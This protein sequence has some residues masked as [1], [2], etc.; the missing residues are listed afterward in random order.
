MR[1]ARSPLGVLALGLALAGCRPRAEVD[2]SVGDAGAPEAPAASRT[3]RMSYPAG[4]GS[5]VDVVNDARGAIVSIHS[6]TPIKS[7]PAAMFPG[8]GD[9]AADVALGTG[10]LI[11]AHGV[12]VVT[13][14]HIVSAASELRV[15]TSDRKEIV[16]RVIGRDP[17]L[18]LALLQVDAPRLPTL[19]L[20]N[21]KDLDVGEW[22]V[23]LGD[24]FGDEV[25]ASAGI[26]SATGR[27][28]FGSAVAGPAS[29]YRTYLQTD[30]R[31]HRGNSGGPVLDTAGQVIGVAVATDD[32]PGEISFAIPIDQVK[33]VIESLREHG[34]VERAYLGATVNS[35]P[36][37][38]QP[39]L[40]QSGGAV[41]TDVSRDTPA[42][43]A[44]LRT[45]DV[46][47]EWDGRE[48]DERSLPPLVTSAVVGKRIPV[49]IFR[50]GATVEVGVT[51]EKLPD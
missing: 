34:S 49:T 12:F 23:V 38:M 30:A 16:A 29:L 15:V 41:I 22:V 43:R 44:G 18:D 40:P 21:S 31:I 5:F 47:L 45:G 33:N 1:A 35:V 51:P 36:A 14:E 6:T 50:D 19:T 24:P 46:I 3:S 7:G 17:R 20:G 9:A 8:A 48:V 37:D 42:A 39:A 26:V 27:T 32:R 25:T 10:F 13:N 4:H 11:Q 2:A 28:G